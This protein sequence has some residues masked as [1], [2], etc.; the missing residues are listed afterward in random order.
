MVL[1]YSKYLLQ[2]IQNVI[3]CRIRS[4]KRRLIILIMLSPMLSARSL[5]DLAETCFVGKNSLY[6]VL[7]LRR[8]E[9]W[10]ASIR[11]EGMYRLF[12]HLLRLKCADSSVRSRKCITL[13]ADD[14]TRSVRGNF[15]GIA[16]CCYSGAEKRTVK[17]IRTRALIAVIGEGKKQIVLDV[18]VVPPKSSGPG[19]PRYTEG[20]WLI[21][22]LQRIEAQLNTRE[23]SLRGCY[24]SVD[25]A[26]A[27]GYV[28]R[29][30]NELGLK[31]VS[32]VKA[33]L[34]THWHNILWFPAG[35]YFFLIEMLFQKKFRL[36]TGESE[37]EYYRHRAKIRVYGDVLVVL[38]RIGGETK[39][40]FTNDKNMKSITIRRVAKRRWQLEQVFWNLKQLLGIT[41]IHNQNKNRALVR[42]YLC[43]VMAQAIKDC[44]QKLKVTMR[45]L[46][47]ILERNPKL[48]IEQINYWCTSVLDE[49]AKPTS[50]LNKRKL[51]EA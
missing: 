43:F 39:R 27:P 40:L 41:R 26:Y 38:M 29:Y 34:K 6:E 32:E 3:R 16:H 33:S 10:L 14:S 11:R 1:F 48:L 22:A 5:K 24:L 47:K 18:H 20:Q 51:R 25:S 4:N 9:T 45:K 37:I 28:L 19:R 12:S 8:P 36:L 49:T 31:F 46:H 30:A 35:L 21:S 50:T 44:S 17:G 15:G 42:I 23:L 13:C 2:A 7:D